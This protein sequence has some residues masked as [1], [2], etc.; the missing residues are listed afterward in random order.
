MAARMDPAELMVTVNVMQISRRRFI[1]MR[2]V[3]EDIARIGALISPIAFARTPP[4]KLPALP[5]P[6]GL[7]DAAC[8]PNAKP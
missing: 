4:P 5:T 7:W 2:A 6:P 8:I 1:H 3:R